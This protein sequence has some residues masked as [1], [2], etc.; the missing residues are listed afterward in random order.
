MKKQDNPIVSIITPTYNSSKYIQETIESVLA[1]TYT[2]W[3]LVITDDYS[4]DNTVDIIKYFQSKD[5][6]I[7][8]HQLEKNF[9]AALARNNSI[10]NSKGGFLAF[11]DSDDVWHKE[12]LQSQLKFMGSEI[13]FSFTAFQYIDRSSVIKK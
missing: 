8:L 1:Q 5:S 9:G 10:K 3:E 11:L 4:N 7:K 2:Q 6:R 12:K 13:H